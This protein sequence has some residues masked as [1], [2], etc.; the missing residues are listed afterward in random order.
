MDNSASSSPSL[1]ILTQTASEVRPYY[2]QFFE[3]LDLFFVTFKQ[4]NS[5]AVDFLPGSTWS[6][7]RNRLWEHVKGKYDYYLFVDDDLEFFSLPTALPTSIE[8]FLHRKMPLQEKL[9]LRGV[10]SR[11]QQALAH[12][13]ADPA[14]F[15]RLLFDKLR[16]YRPLVASLARRE[17]PCEAGT[18]DRYALERNRRVRPLGWFDAQATIFSDLAAHLLLPYDTDF[19]GWWSSQIPIYL[20]GHLAFKDRAINI[21]DLATA[22]SNHLVYRPGYDGVRDCLDMSG[23]L[24]AGMLDPNGSRLDL[25]DGSFIDTNY[26][27]EF[28]K[29][30]A[31]PGRWAD[32]TLETA[33]TILGQSFDLH[34]P[35]IYSRHKELVDALGAKPNR[36]VT[37][38]VH[39]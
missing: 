4:R 34:H 23:W 22:N 7:G 17:E 5:E 19:S 27:G 39:G 21:L 31:A 33:L 38:K 14:Q 8:A 16:T 37:E 10:L 28:A 29:S 11:V 13:K 15:R 32:E 25:A 35:Y 6:H 26:A 2:R 24:A 36:K 18:V 12:K 1:C 20:L 9:H 3:G 30:K